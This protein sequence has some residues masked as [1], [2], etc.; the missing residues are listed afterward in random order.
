[1]SGLEAWQPQGRFYFVTQKTGLPFANVFL[2]RKN[3]NVVLILTRG[4]YVYN[5][6]DSIKELLQ[7]KIDGL[8]SF[9]PQF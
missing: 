4:P 5:D 9:R 6:P 1:V 8:L 2:L 7:P 3:N